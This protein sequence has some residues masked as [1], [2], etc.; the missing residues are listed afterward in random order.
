MSSYAE[1]EVSFIGGDRKKEERDLLDELREYLQMP[2]QNRSSNAIEFISKYCQGSK[3]LVSFLESL[4]AEN[5]PDIIT[6]LAKNFKYQAYTEGNL[7]KR[8]GEYDENFSLIITGEVSLLGIKLNKYFLTKDE[9]CEHI[10][11]LKFFGEHELAKECIA[12]N[13]SILPNYFF[14]RA[15]QVKKRFKK[16]AKYN[17]EEYISETSMH[18]DPREQIETKNKLH[19]T[20]PSYFF[21]KKLLPGD[22]IG[23]LAFGRK[24]QYLCYFNSSEF[25]EVALIEKRDVD[26]E[27][28]ANYVTISIQKKLMPV[29]KSYFLFK[30]LD[31]ELFREYSKYFEFYKIKKGDYIIK[32]DTKSSVV[33]FVKEGEFEITTENSIIGLNLLLTELKKSN[34][35]F[36]N[37][38]SYLEKVEVR[39]DLFNI[40]K[41]ILNPLFRTPE[42]IQHSKEI[43]TIHIA[44]ITSK[45]IL[46]LS[47]FFSFKTEINHFNCRCTKDAEIFVISKE[48]F[49][50]ILHKNGFLIN[51]CARMIEDKATLYINV[52]NRVKDD[53]VVEVEKLIGHKQH[54]KK[55]QNRDKIYFHHLNVLYQSQNIETENDPV[56]KKKML[57]KMKLLSPLKSDKKHLRTIS[58]RVSVASSPLNAL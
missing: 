4:S 30:D 44:D 53:F 14:S 20:I 35:H 16:K 42:F 31:V 22:F 46:G 19:L 32:Q 18:T 27:R 39:A 25:T 21:V 2:G 38:V 26:C 15:P 45:Q 48:S 43:K 54:Y 49:N 23:N 33:F 40:E 1:T 57:R 5:T 55:V 51:K 41:F 47:E 34:A 9:F 3:K 37:Y 24:K 36:L 6:E 56:I 13:E 58:N 11:K 8:P 29:V 12:Y 50:N 7:V 52:I 28:L 10:A 17:L